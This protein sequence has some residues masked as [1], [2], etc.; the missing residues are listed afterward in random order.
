MKAHV[1]TED[2]WWEIYDELIDLGIISKQL[3]F[4]KHEHLPIWK[5]Y[6]KETFEVDYHE[7]KS[8]LSKKY[9]GCF[10]FKS[11]AEFTMFTLRV[12]NTKWAYLLN[13]KEQ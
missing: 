9:W 5:K 8:D 10:R 13:I 2:I 6:F 11:P 1:L 4:E 3:D 7:T 12:A